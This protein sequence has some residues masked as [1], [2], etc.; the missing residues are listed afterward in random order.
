MGPKSSVSGWILVFAVIG[1]ICFS[2]CV[3]QP[4][5]TPSPSQPGAELATLQTEAIDLSEV[6]AGD[7]QLQFIGFYSLDALDISLQTAQYTLPLETDEITN[8][9]EFS[10]SI[11]LGPDALRLLETNGF[12]VISNPFYSQTEAITA[13]YKTLKDREIPVFIT[14]DSLLHLYHIQF[15]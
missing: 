9:N 8:F 15:D 10:K 5:V 2:G 11:S 12:V 14:S 1:L 3:E 4:T 7:E 6:H 13:P